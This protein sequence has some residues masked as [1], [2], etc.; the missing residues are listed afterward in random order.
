MQTA[1]LNQR[2]ITLALIAVLIA[3]ERIG[4]ELMG[5]GGSFFPFAENGGLAGELGLVLLWGIGH[6]DTLDGPVVALARKA[7]DVERLW[8][9]A[10]GEAHGHHPEPVRH[11]HKAH[12]RAAHAH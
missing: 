5:T 11:E 10:T 7:L 2:T 9:A 1:R 8:Q 3:L 6:C 4:T 12:E